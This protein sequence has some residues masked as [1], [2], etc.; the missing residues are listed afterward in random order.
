MF[1]TTSIGFLVLGIIALNIGD[2][3]HFRAIYYSGHVI[4]VVATNCFLFALFDML[5]SNGWMGAFFAFN[6]L[7]IAGSYRSATKQ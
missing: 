7:L 3:Q 1:L 2:N 4:F 6:A 5:F